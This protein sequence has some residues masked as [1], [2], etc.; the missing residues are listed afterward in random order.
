MAEYVW[1]V[2]TELEGNHFLHDEW[3]VQLYSLIKH[4]ENLRREN[5]FEY[6]DKEGLW[7]GPMAQELPTEAVKEV[8]GYLRVNFNKLPSDVPFRRVY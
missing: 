4:A 2:M 6:K 8:D 5:I 7:I 1:C 3:V